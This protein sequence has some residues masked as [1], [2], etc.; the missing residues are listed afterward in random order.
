LTRTTGIL[1]GF[2]YVG[3]LAFL[4]FLCSTKYDQL[5]PIFTAAFFYLE[6]LLVG[7]YCLQS[8]SEWGRLSYADM[9][10]ISM[11]A[12]IPQG[13]DYYSISDIY[14]YKGQ[15]QLYGKEQRNRC[16]IPIVS[17]SFTE[18]DTVPVWLLCHVGCH[19]IKDPCMKRILDIP[20][21][22]TVEGV[23]VGGLLPLD[24]IQ[25]TKLGNPTLVVVPIESRQHYTKELRKFVSSFANRMFCVDLVLLGI[26]LGIKAFFLWIENEIV[27]TSNSVT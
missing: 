8:L 14:F 11:N 22:G 6:V 26:M 24:E 7:I 9:S 15:P 17:S 27:E 10:V 4:L 13:A 3:V 23:T 1:Y 21:G 16:A 18:G 19:D 5:L 12:P 2:F 25:E 20:Q